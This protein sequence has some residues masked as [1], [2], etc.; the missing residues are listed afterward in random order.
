MRELDPLIVEA[1]KRYGVEALILRT[2]CFVESR[3][4][5]DVV[6]PKGARGLMQFMPDTARRYGLQNPD[7][8]RAAIDAAARYLRDLLRKFGGRVDLALADYNSGE[9]TVD[10]FRTGNRLVLPN[11]KVINPHGLVTGG[12]PPYRETQEYVKSIFGFLTHDYA[13][14]SSLSD[15]PMAARKRDLRSRD[16]TLDIAAPSQPS[17]VRINAA[18]SFIEIP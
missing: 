4:R 10:S 9:G 2:M 1:S 7:D 8:P 16:F 13:L 6:S 18:S 11:G 12:I 15:T 3:Y 17:P 5:I 14:R